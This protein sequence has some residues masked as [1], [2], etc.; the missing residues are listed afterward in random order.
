MLPAGVLLQAGVGGAV[1]AAERALVAGEA[2]QVRGL[3]VADQ[4]H[5]HLAGVAAVQTAPAR[6]RL[7]TSHAVLCLLLPVD[8]AVAVL[9]QEVS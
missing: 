3:N 1:A 2:G 5:A 9:G 4:E 7:A 8:A 6:P